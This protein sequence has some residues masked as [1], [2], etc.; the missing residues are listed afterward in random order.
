MKNDKTFFTARELA[1]R[2]G[3][4]ESRIRQLLI[5]G[6]LRGS[7]VG[8]TWIIDS[9]EAARWLVERERERR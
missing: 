9:Q 6:R 7:K 3:L 1:Q 4:S 5:A 8:A 2:A